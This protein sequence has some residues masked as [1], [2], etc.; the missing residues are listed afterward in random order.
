MNP[1]PRKMQWL[2]PSK[3]I[4]KPAI[5]GQLLEIL[6]KLEQQC[7]PLAIECLLTADEL[8]GKEKIQP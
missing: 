4:H 3:P 7:E 1:A 8:R 2:E 5:H 6:D